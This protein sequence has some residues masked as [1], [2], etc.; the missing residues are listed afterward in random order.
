MPPE[1]QA[2]NIAVGVIIPVTA[3]IM[4]VFIIVCLYC[5]HVRPRSPKEEIN[6]LYSEIE[7][8]QKSYD[9]VKG[10][11][12]DSKYVETPAVVLSSQL[13]SQPINA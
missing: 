4:V 13:E 5:I 6:G 10:Q 11:N 2:A 9:F 3:I 8:V 12:R 1:V 7:T